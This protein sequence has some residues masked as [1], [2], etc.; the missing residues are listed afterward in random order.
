MKIQ[1]FDIG[2]WIYPDS[3]ITESNHLI[4]LHSARNSDTCFQIL[5]DIVA[6][7]GTNVK[8]SLETPDDNISVVVN[9]LRPVL[10]KYNS[11][12]VNYNAIDYDNVKDFITR[13][14]PFEVYDLTRPIDDGMLWGDTGKTA[15][16]VQVN[17]AAGASTGKKELVLR[18]T[19]GDEVTDINI[20]LHVHKSILCDASDSPY[21]MGYWIIVPAVCYNHGVERFSEKYYHYVEQNLKQMKN[22][23]CNHIQLPT[24]I[25]VRDTEGMIVDFDF[26][27]CDRYTEMAKKLGFRYINSGFVATWKAWRDSKYYL[28]WDED[29]E[30]E[31]MEGY[32]QLRIYF[33]RTKEFIERHQL[34]N[35]YWQS[36][37]DEPQLENSMAYKALACTCRKFIPNVQIMD[38]VE[39]P[40]VVGSCDIWIVKQAVYEKYK[41]QYDSLMEMGEKLWVYSCGFPANKWMNHIIDL[42]LAATRLIIW[43]GIKRGIDGFM[44]Y[45]YH[46]FQKGMDPMYDTNFGRIYQKEMRYFPPGN[47]GVIYTDGEVIYDSVRA[48]VQRISAAE[49]E[50]FLKLREKDSDACNEIIGSVCT[51]FEEY[52]S[53]SVQIENARR[54]LLEKLDGFCE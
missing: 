41:E 2:T 13:K 53:D 46:E 29:T 1:T 16:L 15:F 20:N 37:V 23:R 30:V 10:V 26:S 18:L 49:G 9:E 35:L 11:G 5:T 31:S 47:H 45:G 7:K 51:T 28:H 50:L 54:V 21:P 19:I 3:Q 52:V 25:P 12:A 39:T 4:T 34:G 44:H 32:R 8:W 42:P 40:N 48:H 43:E 17:V 14:A 27:E 38:P 24:P 6:S 36:F 22:M 33:Q